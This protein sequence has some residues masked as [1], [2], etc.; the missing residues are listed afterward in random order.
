[1]H[2]PTKPASGGVVHDNT[3]KV[4][5]AL[6]GAGAKGE[7]RELE[8]SARTAAEAAA[9]L[10]CPVGAIANSLVF[11]ADS[12]PI[13]VLTSGAHRVDTTHLA[14]QLGVAQVRRAT[15][16]EV[17]S[18]TG[19]P[20]GGVSPVGHHQPVETYIDIALE[21]FPVI[22]AAAG[23]PHAVFKTSYRELVR[24]C[25]AAPVTVAPD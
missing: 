25:P 5:A 19:Q 11:L 2:P 20:I 16:P 3:A 12:R 13:L 21:A 6:T 10:G 24:I 22:W 4:A 17:R 18:A 9:A 15:A 7:I 14:G 23:T 8:E 1:M